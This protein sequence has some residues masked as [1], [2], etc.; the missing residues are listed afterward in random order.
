MYFNNDEVAPLYHNNLKCV[1]EE[2]SFL[3]FNINNKVIMI[4]IINED[5]VVIPTKLLNEVSS[6]FNI[7]LCR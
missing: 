4:I 3:Y 1:K 5:F 6:L 2:G 7:S